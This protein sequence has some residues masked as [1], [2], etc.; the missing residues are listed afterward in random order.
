M[1]YIHCQYSAF[2]F[3]AFLYSNSL[4]SY[5]VISRISSNLTSSD[6][7][8]YSSGCS[9]TAPVSNKIWTFLYVYS[10]LLHNPLVYPL[11]E[12]RHRRKVEYHAIDSILIVELLDSKRNNYDLDSGYN[13]KLKHN[14]G[15]LTLFH[16]F[17][18]RRRY[19]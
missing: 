14:T 3:I 18:F 4:C 5:S 10:V 8:I 19:F 6:L 11:L 1:E 15:L 16:L 12:R 13:M 7:N 17:H 2:A 9:L